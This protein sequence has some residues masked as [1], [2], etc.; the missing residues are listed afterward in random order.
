VR[1]HHLGEEELAKALGEAEVLRK[2]SHS[3]IIHCVDSFVDDGKFC[4]V[5]DFADG[6]EAS[7]GECLDSSDTCVGDLHTAIKKQ[8]A[9]GALFAE[10]AV[11]AV[12]TRSTVDG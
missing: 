5:T 11:L 9:T 7:L 6:G 1:T 3:N 10:R 8:K 2:L 12:A 4:I